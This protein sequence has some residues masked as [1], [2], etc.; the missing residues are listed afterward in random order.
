MD[1]SFCLLDWERRSRRATSSRMVRSLPDLVAYG[2]NRLQVLR[3]GGTVRQREVPVTRGGAL[4]HLTHQAARH[5]TVGLVPGPEIIRNL[6]HRPS[7][8]GLAIR[9]DVRDLGILRTLRIAGKEA[10]G[11]HRVAEPP[12]R[13]A[14]AAVAHCLDEILAARD[15]AR[16]CGRR[17]RFTR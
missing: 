12:R 7:E 11:V 1:A 6:L 10:T 14:L 15:S 3:D 2:R 17:W 16:G 13:V 8:P 4:D 5:V 9:C